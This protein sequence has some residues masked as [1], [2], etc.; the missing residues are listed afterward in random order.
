MAEYRMVDVEEQPYL[1]CEGRCSMDPNDISK[2]M[3]IAFQTVGELIAK[4]GIK[5]ATMP[6]SVYC[7]YDEQIMSFRAGFLVSAEDAKRA[8]GDVK[9]AVLPAGKVLNFIHRGPYAKLRESYGEM[10]QYLEDNGMTV[11][12]PSWEVYLN[13][14]GTVATEEDLETDIYVAVSGA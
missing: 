2:H 5:S 12:A 14:P 3:G 11:G 4:K 8:G 13:E 10:M 9:S 6:L 1:Y 7:D